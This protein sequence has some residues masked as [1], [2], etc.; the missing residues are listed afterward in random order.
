M[1]D[2]Q[3]TQARPGLKRMDPNDSIFF[4]KAP[5]ECCPTALTLVFKRVRQEMSGIF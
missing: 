2:T 5:E 4:L 1:K 3:V